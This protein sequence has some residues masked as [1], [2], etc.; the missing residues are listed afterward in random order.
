M[1]LR[2]PRSVARVLECLRSLQTTTRSE[3]DRDAAAAILTVVRSDEEDPTI[4]V[5]HAHSGRGSRYGFSQ[6]VCP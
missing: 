1:T 5:K 6:I 3:P 2:S 4:F